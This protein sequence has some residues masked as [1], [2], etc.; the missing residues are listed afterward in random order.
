[1]PGPGLEHCRLHGAG[2][3]CGESGA[4]FA[5]GAVHA[6]E[7]RL[8]HRPVPAAQEGAEIAVGQLHLVAFFV[9]DH[10][11]GQI[12]VAEHAEHVVGRV[13]HLPRRRQ[14]LL[15]LRGQGVG[16]LPQQQPQHFAVIGKIRVLRQGF[17]P[18]RRQGQ[19]FGVQIRSRALRLHQQGFQLGRPGLADGIGPVLMLVHDSVGGHPVHEAGEV[20]AGDH[21]RLG[22]LPHPALKGRHFADA[23][24][25]FRERLLVGLL[26]GENMVQPPLPAGVHILAVF[27]FLCHCG[28]SLRLCFVRQGQ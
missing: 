25:C 26:R 17:Q 19:Q 5:V 24:F 14:Q 16:L 20:V 10:G 13:E 3:S 18:L 23:A 28:I 21:G 9:P 1:M 12:H 6:L 27:Q 7:G 2:V 15:L 4:E 22:V 11:Q 8:A